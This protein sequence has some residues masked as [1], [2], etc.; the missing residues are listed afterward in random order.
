MRAILCMLLRW[1]TCASL[2]MPHP[3][4]LPYFTSPLLWQT[5][6]PLCMPHPIG[7]PYFTSLLP[8]QTCAPGMVQAWVGHFVTSITLPLGCSLILVYISLCSST[9]DK[10][11]G[12]DETAQKAQTTDKHH[13]NGGGATCPSSGVDLMNPCRWSGGR[14]Y[15][16]FFRRRHQSDLIDSIN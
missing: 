4:S 12:P 7:L 10:W 2:C 16:W 8:W 6:I 3:I 13:H 9:Y 1:Q 5:C 14:P 11:R 15:A